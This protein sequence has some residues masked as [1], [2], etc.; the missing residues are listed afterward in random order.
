MAS[1]K[2]ITICCCL[3]VVLM[4]MCDKRC[5]ASTVLVAGHGSTSRHSISERKNDIGVNPRKLGVNPADCTASSGC[6]VTSEDDIQLVV[7][8]ANNDNDDSKTYKVNVNGGI[9]FSKHFD[10]DNLYSG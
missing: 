5:S 6:S 3:Y 10:E 2:G 9:G 8:T 7:R 4:N 1:V